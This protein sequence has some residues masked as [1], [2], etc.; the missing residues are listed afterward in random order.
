MNLATWSEGTWPG[1][2]I[3]H[4]PVP[5]HDGHPLGVKRRWGFLILTDSLVS[6]KFLFLPHRS[7]FELNSVNIV[8]QPVHS[9]VGD[10]RIP[11][12]ITIRTLRSLWDTI[13]DAT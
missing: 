6:V 8:D 3:E 13:S 5:I 10:G 12:M 11:D 7:S 1:V 9:G 2:P 4:P